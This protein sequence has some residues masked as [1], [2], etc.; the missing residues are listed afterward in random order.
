MLLHF[1]VGI[2]VCMGCSWS[3]QKPSYFVSLVLRISL[4]VQIDISKE[5]NE[6]STSKYTSKL[7]HEYVAKSVCCVQGKAEKWYFTRHQSRHQTF[8]RRHSSVSVFSLWTARGEN[9]QYNIVKLK[10]FIK[11]SKYFSLWY[12]VFLNYVCKVTSKCRCQINIVNMNKARMHCVA[13]DGNGS[14]CAGGCRSQV[15]RGKVWGMVG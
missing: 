14:R 15:I 4:F 5:I 3:H 13:D 8:I 2:T 7:H 10:D 12:S 9:L 11:S 1:S 6:S